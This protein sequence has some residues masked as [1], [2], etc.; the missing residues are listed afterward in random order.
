M[1]MGLGQVGSAIKQIEVEAGNIVYDYDLKVSPERPELPMDEHLDVL[2]VCIPF[3]KSFILDVSTLINHYNPELTIIHSTVPV[4]TTR[5]ILNKTK[6]PVVHSYVRGI[7]PNLYSGI[8]EFVKYVGALPAHANDAMFHLST[9]GLKTEYL[10]VPEYTELAKIADTTYYGWNILFAKELK[11]ITDAEKL[12]F[13]TVY[14]IP[15][16]SYNEGYTNLGMKNVVRP[17]LY[18]PVGK[19]GGH[20]VSENFELLPESRLKKVCKELNV[21]G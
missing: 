11:K 21:K 14:N 8:K 3:G 13:H 5:K 16:Q 4:G 19:I 15:N 12:D 9:L 1:M 2:N 17:I 10:G 6:T 7:H 18:P 20:C